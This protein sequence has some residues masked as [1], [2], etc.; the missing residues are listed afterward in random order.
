MFQPFPRLTT[1][2]ILIRVNKQKSFIFQLCWTSTYK[3]ASLINS[4]LSWQLHWLFQQLW[5]GSLYYKYVSCKAVWIHCLI[6]NPSSQLA[7]CI[8]VYCQ[9]IR[10]QEKSGEDRARQLLGEETHSSSWKV[11]FRRNKMSPW[12]VRNIFNRFLLPVLQGSVCWFD[13]FRLLVLLCY[14]T[15]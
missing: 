14:T 3:F 5:G 7:N 2:H 12:S 6:R 1:L 8:L 4:K 10:P 15:Y 13:G 9:Y 11:E